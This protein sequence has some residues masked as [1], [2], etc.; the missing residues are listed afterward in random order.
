[1]V[2]V[3]NVNVLIMPQHCTPEMV[4]MVSF[5]LYHKKIQLFAYYRLMMVT[6]KRLTANH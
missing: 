5:M 2:L 1:M 4:K 3:N 6:M